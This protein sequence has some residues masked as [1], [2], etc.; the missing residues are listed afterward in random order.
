M[1]LP[2]RSYK[3][4]RFLPFVAFQCVAL[5]VICPQGWGSITKSVRTRIFPKT[6]STLVLTSWVAR[7]YRWKVGSKKSRPPMSSSGTL[8]KAEI[9]RLQP[10]LQNLTRS[11]MTENGSTHW[12]RLRW[13]GRPR[14]YDTYHLRGAGQYRSGIPQ[15]C[16]PWFSIK[17]GSLFG[18]AERRGPII[19][20]THFGP[21]SSPP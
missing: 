10:V 19:V 15:V 6:F 20:L 9:K 2:D 4:M 7:E 17:V 14:F 13:R 18:C 21:I 3:S 8:L 1:Q 5:R 11:R 12:L 16:S